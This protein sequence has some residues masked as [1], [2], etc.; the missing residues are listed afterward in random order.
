MAN[1]NSVYLI[2]NLTRDPELKHLPNGTAVCD[3]GIAINRTWNDDSGAKKEE[4]TFVDV[5]FW[6][7]TAETVS[8]YCGKGDPIF[9]EGRLTV[10]SW[11]D[12]DSGQN[13]SKMKVTGEGFQ[14]LKGKDQ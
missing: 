2:G 10:E 3:I 14:F 12:K 1:L 8:K 9:I 13:R 4:T 7:K 5:T 6:G 11:V